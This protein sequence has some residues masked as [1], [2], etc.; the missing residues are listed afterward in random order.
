MSHHVWM[1]RT[2]AAAREAEV[3]MPWSRRP[4]DKPTPP[5]EAPAAA[6]HAEG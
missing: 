3:T 4:A 5:G 1:D 2:I 6:R